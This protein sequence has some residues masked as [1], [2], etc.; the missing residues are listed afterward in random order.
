MKKDTTNECENKC[1][2]KCTNKCGGKKSPHKRLISNIIFVVLIILFVGGTVCAIHKYHRFMTYQYGHAFINKSPL[3]KSSCSGHTSSTKRATMSKS[4][5]QMS[6]H[7]AAMGQSGYQ[8]S[9]PTNNS[10]LTEVQSEIFK[11][12][13]KLELE[14]RM[15]DIYT[16]QAVAIVDA[17]VELKESTTSQ[18]EAIQKMKSALDSAE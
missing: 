9:Q 15:G 1:V 11:D 12:A 8:H 5:Q 6:A 2:E 17:L 7:H 13:L 10:L 14:E 4:Y 16:D 18:Q 3:A